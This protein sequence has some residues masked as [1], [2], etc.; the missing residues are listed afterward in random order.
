MLGR[1]LPVAV[2][3]GLIFL[4]SAMPGDPN[5]APTW[6]RWFVFKGGHVVEYAV[7]FLLV[8]R[9]LDGRERAELWALLFCVLYGV[10]DE[11][12]QSFVP[13]RTARATDVLIDA[14]GALSAAFLRTRS[15]PFP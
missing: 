14:V 10:S 3:C 11:V 6:T 15:R 5:P 7:L 9:A 1:W 8:R 13:N 4:G 2:W 12:H